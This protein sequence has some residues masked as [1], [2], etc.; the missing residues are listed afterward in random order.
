[1]LQ[2]KKSGL[3]LKG[4]TKTKEFTG[5]NITPYVPVET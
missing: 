4:G 3:T 5:R 2:I 1:M